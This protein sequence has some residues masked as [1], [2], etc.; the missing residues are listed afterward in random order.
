M[1]K[2]QAD[3]NAILNTLQQFAGAT[4]TSIVSAIIALSQNNKSLSTATSTAIGTQHAFI[5]LVILGLINLVIL[6][7]AI[8]KENHSK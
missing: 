3:G 6:F 5:I 8:P 2:N 1:N 4:G 7:R